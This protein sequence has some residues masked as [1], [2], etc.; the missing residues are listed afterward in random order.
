MPPGYVAGFEDYWTW[1]EKQ[2]GASGGALVSELI[3]TPIPDAQ[4]PREWIILMIQT[5]RIWFPN[6][7][8]VEFEM[9]VNL[10]LEVTRYSYH[11]ASAAGMIWR[12]DRHEGHEDEHGTDTHAHIGC[13][14]NR[15]R[16]DYVEIDDVLGLVR[17]HQDTG[18]HGIG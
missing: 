6:E 3:V 8:F 18:N 4:S 9:A 12:L 16:F 2:I 14:D 17:L 7:Y 1:I 13:D 15:I 5:Q 10:D 11:Y